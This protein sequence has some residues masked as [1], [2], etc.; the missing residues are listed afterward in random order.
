MVSPGTGP[1][2]AALAVAGATAFAL[3]SCSGPEGAGTSDFDLLINTENQEIPAVLSTLAE[4]ECAAEDESLPLSVETVPQN[5]LD[6]Q[7]QLLAGQG[8]LPALYSAGNAPA[9]TETLADSGHVLDFEEA[10]TDLDALDRLEPAAVSTIEDLYGGFR[11]LP[12]EYNI[13]GIWYNQELF[14]EHGVDVPQTWDELVA[15]AETFSEADVLPFS[16]SG[17]QGWPITRFIG[18]YLYRDLGPEALE[19][20][21]NGEVELTDPDYV[22]AAEAVA[23]LGDAGFFG[24]GVGSIDMDTSTNRFLSGEAAMFYMGSWALSDFNDE[25]RNAIGEDNIGFMPFPEVEGGAGNS[26]QLAANVGLPVTMNASALNEET[27]A[28]LTCIA[29]HYGTTA[30]EQENRV[31]GFVVEDEGTDVPLLTQEVRDQVADTDDP[32]LWFEALF[33]TEATDTSQ[34]NAAPLVSGSL[35]AEEFMSMVQSDQF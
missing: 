7:L 32:V 2:L 20:V 8:G 12:F 4:E 21:A 18:N 14:A 33:S 29:D 23:D 22:R 35:T 26:G 1:R 19:L 11:V 31:S 6:Q 17:E 3:T 16:A 27:E 28:W 34:N 9:L 5:N 30:L 15:A 25:E 10:L 24:E 13:E